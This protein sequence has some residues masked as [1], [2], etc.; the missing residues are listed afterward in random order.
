M[1]VASHNSLVIIFS[2]GM[3]LDKSTKLKL[4]KAHKVFKDLLSLV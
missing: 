2:S 4:D 1:D 3:L